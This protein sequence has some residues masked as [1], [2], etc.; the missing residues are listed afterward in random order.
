MHIIS[1]VCKCSMFDEDVGTDDNDRGLD[2]S[3]E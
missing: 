3:F 2:I 1:S